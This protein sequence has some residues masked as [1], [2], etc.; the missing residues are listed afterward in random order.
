MN[1]TPNVPTSPVKI[2]YNEPAHG[3]PVCVVGTVT[4]PLGCLAGT[5]VELVVVGTFAFLVGVVVVG[6]LPVG[7]LTATCSPSVALPVSEDVAKA[8]LLGMNTAEK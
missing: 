8:E 1:Q 3:S 5:L 4:V 2:Q 6:G 7:A